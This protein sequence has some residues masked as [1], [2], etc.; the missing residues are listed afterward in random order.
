MLLGLVL[1][2]FIIYLPPERLKL[3]LNRG[4]RWNK[5]IFQRFISHVTTDG[6]YMW[7]KTLK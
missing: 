1:C 6:G 4:Y 2:A 5:I 7:N 3:V